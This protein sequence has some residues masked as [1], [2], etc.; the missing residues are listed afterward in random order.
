MSV[1]DLLGMPA[2]RGLFRR[3]IAQSGPPNAMSMDRAEEKTA[4]LMAELGIGDPARLRDVPASALLDAQARVV[5]ERGAGPLPIM[6]VVD[7]TSIPV[8]PLR[9]IEEGVARDIPL[10]IGTN[11]D[12]AKLFMVGD[13]KNRDPDEAVLHRRIERA[14]SVNDIALG[15]DD[16]IGA[17][18]SARI[19][20]GQPTD[21]RELW[22]AIE[23]DRMF[24]IGSL[25]AAEA[26]ARQQAATYCY[27]FEWESPAMGGALGSCHA[28]E[29]PFVFGNLAAPTMDRFAGSGPAADRL[30]QQMMDA[31]IAFARTGDPT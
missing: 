3:A 25:R 18:R 24:R 10:V 23:T 14:F 27:L 28:L 31:W 9:A 20:R 16:A 13:P 22:S 29:I 30:S 12:E 4:K 11:R 17:Y 8:P 6:P 2:A 1:C 21:P 26:Q 19:E 15:P 5:A 7:G